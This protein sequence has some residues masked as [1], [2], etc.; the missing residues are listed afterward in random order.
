M[1]MGRVVLGVNGLLGWKGWSLVE[2][3]LTDGRSGEVRKGGLRLVERR[4]RRASSVVE[5][6]WR[7]K[8][9]W[10]GVVV[11]I[12]MVGLSLCRTEAMNDDDVVKSVVC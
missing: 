10:V 8:V 12:V 7:C 11:V 9:G 4:E 6:G 3:G 5:M 1:V 2:E